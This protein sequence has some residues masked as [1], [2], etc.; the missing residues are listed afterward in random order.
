MDRNITQALCEWKNDPKRKPLILRGMRQCGKTWVLK[1]FGNSQYRNL[2]YLSF[3]ENPE[4]RSFFTATRD[5]ER[6]VPQLSVALRQPI[7]PTETLLVLDEIQ[8]CPEALASLKYFQ[9]DRPDYHVACAGSLLGVQL[10]GGRSFPVGKVDFLSLYPMTFSEFLCAA[11]EAALADYLDSV[12]EIE[13][14]PEAFT[15][16]LCELLR[17]YFITGGMPE[18][19]AEW[20]DRQDPQKLERTLDNILAAFQLDFAKHLDASTLRKVLALWGSL[21]AQLARENKK[22]Q[23]N[24]VKDGANAR[25]YADALGWL[26]D[27]HLVNR[28]GRISAPGLPISAYEEPS[29]FKLYAADVGLLRQLSHLDRGAIAQGDQLFTS[30]KGALTENFVQQSLLSVLQAPLRYW[31]SLNPSREV[32][33]ILQKANDIIPIEVKSGED[34][35]GKGLGAYKTRYGD[36]TKLRVRY[37]LLNLS[38][39]DDL[40]NIPL[41]MVDQTAQLL[42]CALNALH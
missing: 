17:F 9:E 8:E 42:E 4:F 36:K 7:N 15:S 22:F 27:A 24:I 26:V 28:I 32:D 38:L 19:V 25:E 40:L 34:S 21:P 23:Y 33:F 30:F 10:Q 16:S 13:A 6:I 37:S 18:A 2:A 41:Y 14:L 35:R 12:R 11:G 5:P 31:A 3:D 1:D 39:T 20:F 29:V